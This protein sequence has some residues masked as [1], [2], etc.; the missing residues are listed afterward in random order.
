[1]Y[2]NWIWMIRSRSSATESCIILWWCQSNIFLAR[3][4]LRKCEEP[5]QVIRTL[6]FLFITQCFSQFSSSK[7]KRYSVFPLHHFAHVVVLLLKLFS[8]I[9]QDFDISLH[10]V[11]Q[12]NVVAFNCFSLYVQRSCFV[13]QSHSTQQTWLVRVVEF[14]VLQ[15][16]V[17]ALPVNLP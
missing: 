2:G 7:S 9:H 14:L 5:Y 16:L 11:R 17:A 1:M 10:F 13:I 8:V 3:K 6:M 12:Q 4:I 15:S